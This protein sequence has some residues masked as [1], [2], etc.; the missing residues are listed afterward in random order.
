LQTAYIRD[1]KQEAKE[2]HSMCILIYCVVFWLGM[3]AM[4]IVGIP[5]IKIVKPQMELDRTLLL[6]IGISQFLVVWRNCYASYLSTTNRVEYWKA[7]MISGIASVAGSVVLM[8][9]GMGCWGIVSAT[10]ITELAYN[11]WKWT[12][13]V[14]RELNLGGM[15]LINLGSRHLVKI[16]KGYA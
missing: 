11:T 4:T 1:D 3:C 13:Q 7:F 9:W 8:N 10:I 14:H 12:I 15:E 6:G 16:L 2:T 5:L